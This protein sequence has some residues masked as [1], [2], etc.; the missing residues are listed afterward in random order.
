MAVTEQP[1]A[2]LYDLLTNPVLSL[3]DRQPIYLELRRREDRKK[4]L[5]RIAEMKDKKAAK[6]DAPK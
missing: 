4:S 3:I 1:E 5:A 2:A 6:E